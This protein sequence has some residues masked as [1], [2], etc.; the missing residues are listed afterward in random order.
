MEPI[1]ARIRR[2]REAR[3]LTQQQLALYL[4]V[5][6]ASVAR[7]ENERKPVLPMRAY[8]APLASALGV[9]LS[10]LLHGE[11][12]KAPSA[13]AVIQAGEERRALQLQPLRDAVRRMR[14]L[15]DEVLEDFVQRVVDL[16]RE[17]ARRHRS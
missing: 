9:S 1:H 10:M 13:G 12:R 8:R 14:A 7:W 16:A 4:D 3:G 11:E 5:A 15:G 2:L 6:V 17:Q